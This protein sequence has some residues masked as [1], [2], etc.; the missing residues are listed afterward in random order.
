MF[1]LQQKV[2]LARE[3]DGTGMVACPLRGMSLDYEH[4]LG[5]TFLEDFRSTEEGIM[6]EIR[7]VPTVRALLPPN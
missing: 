1:G 7:C 3:I 5:C 4:C 2:R 6:V